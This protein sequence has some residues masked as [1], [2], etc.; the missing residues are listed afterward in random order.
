MTAAA[1]SARF[2][3]PPTPAPA[4]DPTVGCCFTCPIAAGCALFSDAYVTCPVTGSTPPPA[5]T[6]AA[7]AQAAPPAPN[8]GV[9]WTNV[10][11]RG[12][13]AA[14]SA[15][16]GFGWLD[17][18]TGLI[19]RFNATDAE[20][21]TV[22]WGRLQLKR[23]GL[24]ILIATLVPLGDHTAAQWVA[25]TLPNLNLN[26]AD[27]VFLPAGAALGAVL[28][29]FAGQFAPGALGG[30][31]R[32]AWGAVAFTARTAWKF[33]TS[34]L[35]WIVIRPAVWGLLCGGLLL[36]WRFLVHVLTGA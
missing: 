28:P 7:P 20:G 22:D 35:G 4:A 14:A 15:A 6:G 24:C 27:P 2:A 23:N 3:K 21:N 11:G 36:T 9:D 32:A 25:H 30:I 12:V 10:A 29:V 19:E 18:A 33:L 16:F 34:P 17:I 13:E 8:G 1:G 31:C 5:P 26:L